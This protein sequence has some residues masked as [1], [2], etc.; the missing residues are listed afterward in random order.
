M[1]YLQVKNWARFQHYKHRK[2]P[3]IRLYRDL[4]DSRDF[5]SLPLASRALAPMIWLLASDTVEGRIEYVP[6][7]IA[8]RLR[9]SV[10]ELQ[11]ALKPLIDNGF[12][13]FASK[14]IATRLQRAIPE[15]ETE[16]ES[17]TE[18]PRASRVS[19]NRFD[20]EQEQRRRLAAQVKRLAGEHDIQVAINAGGGPR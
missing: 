6:E 2:P 14:V 19:R 12:V 1:E 20:E 9:T 15:G 8:F 10:P 13:S 3:W 11:E 17:E 16:R 4:L 7:Q 18:K 5:H